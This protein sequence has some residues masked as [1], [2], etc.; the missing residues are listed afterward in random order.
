MTRRT[1]D[2]RV[3]RTPEEL[4]QWSSAAFVPT[5]GALHE[6][7]RSLIRQ[8]AASTRP[9]VVSVFVN[10]TQFAPGE[11]YQRYPRDLEGDRAKAA[12][13]GADVIFAPA[14]ETMYPPDEDVP[15]PDLPAVA[16]EPGLEDACRPGHFA[17]VAQ[18]V[19]RLFDLV[20]PAV[21]VFG[22]KDYQQ[23][24]LIE[25]LVAHGRHHD[26]KRWGN[27]RIER[28]PTVREADGLAMS[29]RNA[30]LTAAQRE[31]AL[32]LFR[33]LQSAQSAEHPSAAE[34]IM[35]DTLAEHELE[36][37]YAVVRDA[38]TLMPVDSFKRPTRG[39]IAARLGDV[40]LI[41][42]MPLPVS[43]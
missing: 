2:I 26:P 1:T 23:L 16:T 34:T 38:D 18:V 10:P 43:T 27:L 30:Y 32:G 22:E 7:H 36:V 42:N 24:R 9:V 4:T 13:C 12:A 8:A 37:D 29:S 35:R 20:K 33:A 19:A 15:E 14:V 6:G 3:I 39:L 21:A 11:D 5:M 40:R 31:R 28:G 25:Q 17:G 41:D